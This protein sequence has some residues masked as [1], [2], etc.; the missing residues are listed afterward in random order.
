MPQFARLTRVYLVVFLLLLAGCAGDDAY[1]PV[2][3]GWRQSADLP[4]AYIVQ[5]GDT[6]Y[7]IAWNF[8]LDYRKIAKRNHIAAPYAIQTGQ[9]LMLIAPGRSASKQAA[10]ASHATN[11][12]LQQSTVSPYCIPN[13]ISP[14]V[15]ASMPTVA[16]PMQVLSV[17]TVEHAGVLWAWPAH[18]NVICNFCATGL[19]KGIDITG[20]AG[21]PIVAAAAGKVVYAGNGLRGYGNLIIIKHNEEFLSAYAHNQKILVQEGQCVKVG[22]VIALM[23][24]TEAKSVMLHF[25]IRQAG[26]PVNPLNYLPHS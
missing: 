19:N 21:N 16:A 3:E 23:G 2:T 20:T 22:Q 6:L 11:N 10:K 4:Y 1:V 24:N 17:T 12:R 18:G 25:E 9:K 5:P 15:C 13:P 7:S 14:A 26:K 8:G